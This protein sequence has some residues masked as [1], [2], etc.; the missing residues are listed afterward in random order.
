MPRHE[1]TPRIQWS[2][3]WSSIPDTE[4]FSTSSHCA[5]EMVEGLNRA[6]RE[7]S[8]GHSILGRKKNLENVCG[9]TG[10]DHSLECDKKP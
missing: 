2:V 9:W 7:N 5:P 6:I 4:E 3:S 8:S 1:T 10:I